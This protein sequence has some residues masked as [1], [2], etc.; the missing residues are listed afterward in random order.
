MADLYTNNP[1]VNV[2]SLTTHDP[3]EAQGGGGGGGAIKSVAG[4]AFASIKSVS[5]VAIAS[6]KKV[7]GVAAASFLLLYRWPWT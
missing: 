6:V 4:V 1:L 2:S 3:D 5:G 7:S